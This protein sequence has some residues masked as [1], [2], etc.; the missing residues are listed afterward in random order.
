MFGASLFRQPPVGSDSSR[1]TVKL[2]A[3]LGA[4]LLVVAGIPFWITNLPISLD[5]PF[6]R[7]TLPFLLGAS[8]ILA[9]IVVFLYNHNRTRIIA[10]FLF[11]SLV[12]LSAT[13]QARVS[14]YYTDDWEQQQQT[15]WQ[16]IWRVPGLK[17]GTVILFHEPISTSDDESFS[18]AINWIYAPGEMSGS[19]PYIVLDYETR[20]GG[21]IPALELDIEISK[22]WRHLNFNSSTSEMLVVDLRPG[23]CLRVL[24]EDDA[25]R[26]N[27]SEEFKR[28]ST[29]SQADNIL[30]APPRELTMP[31]FLARSEPPRD[32][33]FYFQKADLARQAG[34]WQTVASLAQEVS[35]LGFV[36]EDP[37][38]LWVFIEGFAQ[39]GE[40]DSAIALSED[41]LSGDPDLLPYLCKGWQR[42]LSSTNVS[43]EGMRPRLM[44]LGCQFE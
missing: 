1:T 17:E 22:T 4:I 42:I 32:W 10:I 21:T 7:F 29:I 31:D 33:C 6:G 11:G 41:M 38:E 36:P 27:I 8:L 23:S 39:L 2:G 25:F 43:L 14:A 12:F 15:L 3:F 28:A 24:S 44:E 34:D 37:S 26:Y 30:L 16:F 13:R 19:F 5:F 9:S 18:A 20:I 35:K 40:M